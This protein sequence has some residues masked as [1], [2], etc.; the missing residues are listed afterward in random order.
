MGG[1]ALKNDSYRKKPLDIDFKST[2]RTWKQIRDRILE[3]HQPIKDSFF[4]SKGN[5][6][7]FEDSQLAEQLMLHFVNR[8]IPVLPVHDSFLIIRG[9]SHELETVMYEEFEK[10]FGMS[11]SVD[12]SDKPFT[13]SETPQEVDV[14]WIISESDKYSNFTA[15]NPL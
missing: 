1:C 12:G 3:K 4:C 15:R 11:I 14:D 5:R 8:D 13:L 10:M 2:G 6:L 9:L 7:Q